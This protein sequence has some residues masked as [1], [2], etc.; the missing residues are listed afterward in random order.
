[1]PT[2]TKQAGPWGMDVYGFTAE[3]LSNPLSKA[4]TDWS[5]KLPFGALEVDFAGKILAYNDTEPGA[6]ASQVNINQLI[7]QNFFEQIA[8]W[9]KGSLIEEKFR[10]GVNTGQVNVVFDCPVTGDRFTLRFHL[11]KS[12]ILGSF[13]I[14]VKK[15]G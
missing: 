12:L 11:K 8:P 7:G 4:G 10:E 3:E 1:M 2:I 5:R 14:F 15:I 9:T 6:A 13:W